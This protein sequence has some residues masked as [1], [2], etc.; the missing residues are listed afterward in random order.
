MTA[1]DQTTPSPKPTGAHLPFPT[2]PAARVRNATAR[3]QHSAVLPAQRNVKEVILTDLR[4]EAWYP[5]FYPEDLVGRAVDRL[6]VCTWC[7]RYS[8]QLV[9]FLEHS[10]VRR[11]DISAFKE[12]GSYNLAEM[13]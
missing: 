2:S 4:I 1:T 8:T 7:F 3:A 11:V 10:K 6:Y 13:M 5:S 9:Q 12:Q